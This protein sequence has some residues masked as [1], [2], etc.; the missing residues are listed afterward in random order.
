MIQSGLL[1]VGGINKTAIAPSTSA[2]TNVSLI[3]CIK[4]LQFSDSS[5][6]QKIYLSLRSSISQR[7]EELIRYNCFAT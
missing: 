1:F 2:F 7:F 5:S 4:D 3:G 6:T